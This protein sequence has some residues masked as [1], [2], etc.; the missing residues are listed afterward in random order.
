MRHL[1]FFCVRPARAH[2]WRCKSSPQLI[3]AQPHGV[4]YY[5]RLDPRLYLPH[6]RCS[7]PH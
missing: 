2:S 4:Y 5:D 1:P 7:W 3:Q 6:Q